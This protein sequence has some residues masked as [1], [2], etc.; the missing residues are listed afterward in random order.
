MYVGILYD[1]NDVCAIEYI[2]IKYPITE[3]FI[4]NMIYLKNGSRAWNENKY[5]A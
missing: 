2:K 5:L 4:S 3:K 1:V